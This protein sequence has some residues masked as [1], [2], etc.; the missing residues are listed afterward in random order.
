MKPWHYDGILY[1]EYFWD[2]ANK[3]EFLDMIKQAKEN[4]TSAMAKRD[5]EG[6]EKLIA[7]AQA[8]ADKPNNFI[9]SVGMQF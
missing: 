5:A 7:L 4:F 8:E 9:R 6:G 1:E 2:F 3:T